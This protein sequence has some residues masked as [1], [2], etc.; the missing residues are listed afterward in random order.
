MAMLES[1]TPS[2]ADVQQTAAFD[3]PSLKKFASRLLT[4]GDCPVSDRPFEPNRAGPCVRPPS[5]APFL[6]LKGRWLTRAGFAIGSKV[7]VEVSE[8]RLVIEA[9]T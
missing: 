9:L 5:A 6:R 3:A 1:T 4:V 7:R 8:G 2:P